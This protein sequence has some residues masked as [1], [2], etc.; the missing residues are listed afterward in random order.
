MFLPKKFYTMTKNLKTKKQ[1]KCKKKKTQPNFEEA[2]HPN[3]WKKKG[4]DF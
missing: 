2:C 3:S 1:K 4:P